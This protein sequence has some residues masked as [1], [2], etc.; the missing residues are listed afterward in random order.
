MLDYDLSDI[1]NSDEICWEYAPDTTDLDEEDGWT[2]TDSGIMI[3]MN[4]IT[5]GLI[6]VTDEIKLTSLNQGNVLEWI[7][8]LDALFDAGKSV[9]SVETEE[10]IIPIR[11]R[12]GDLKDHIGLKVSANTWSKEKFDSY[13]RQVR[14]HRH[15]SC[16]D[17]EI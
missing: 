3:R 8:R 7:Y 10:G 14:M 2:E 4:P 17:F 11:F 15:L 13:I 16:N 1:K 6:A 12:I 9:L 5:L